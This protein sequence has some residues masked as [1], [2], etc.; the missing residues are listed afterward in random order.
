MIKIEK[1]Q[2]IEAL[3]KITSQE[4]EEILLMQKWLKILLFLEMKLL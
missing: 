1:Q 4:K 2:V 3:K